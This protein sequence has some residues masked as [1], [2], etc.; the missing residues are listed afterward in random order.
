MTKGVRRDRSAGIIREFPHCYIQ[1]QIVILSAGETVRRVLSDVCMLNANAS[2]FEVGD[3]S[4]NAWNTK[5]GL[6]ARVSFR[7]FA[8]RDIPLVS[9]R[10]YGRNAASIFKNISSMV[11]GLVTI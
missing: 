2:R 11:R 3:L 1:R 4:A 6:M 8:H 7:V 10:N 9:V 5:A